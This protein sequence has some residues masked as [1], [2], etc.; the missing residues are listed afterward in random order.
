MTPIVHN[1]E[2]IQIYACPNNAFE[3]PNNAFECPTGQIR[4]ELV[5][6]TLSLVT[7]GNALYVILIRDHKYIG[8]YSPRAHPK[9]KE[10]I[11]VETSA[12]N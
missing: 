8:K 12:T 9:A 3:C 11:V 7:S 10:K 4:T 2:T 6:Y 1:A 5:T